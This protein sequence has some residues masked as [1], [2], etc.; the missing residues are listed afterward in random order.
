MS[1]FRFEIP[2]GECHFDVGKVRSHTKNGQRRAKNERLNMHAKGDHPYTHDRR[3]YNNY[4]SHT[5]H[6]ILTLHFLS[7]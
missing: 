5:R 6:L 1:V 2:V 7:L 4:I 3:V